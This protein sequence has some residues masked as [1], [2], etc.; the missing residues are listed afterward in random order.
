MSIDPD[1]TAPSRVVMHL[2]NFDALR[3]IFS[4]MV[5]FFH[6]GFL[7][8]SEKLNW[9]TLISATFAVQAFFFLSGFLVV[10][11]YVRSSNS[12]IY[13]L[14]RARRILPAYVAVVIGS[15]I[16]LVF[17]SRMEYIEYFLSLEF[18]KYVG[19]NIIFLNFNA[20]T[21]PGVFIENVEQAVNASLWTIKIEVAFYCIVPLVVLAIKRYNY[22]VVLATLFCA[23]LLWRLG[24]E[25]LG[26]SYGS[27]FFLK[28][29][30]QLPGQLSYFVAGAFSYYRAAEGLKSPTLFLTLCALLIYYFSEG[31]FFTFASPICVGIIVYWIAISAP[32]L[33]SPSAYGDFSYGIYLVHFPLVQAF[34]SLGWYSAQPSLALIS[35]LICILCFATF[36]WFFV[37]RPFIQGSFF[38]G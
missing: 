9:L 29:A 23:S 21:L 16:L 32:K 35:T 4:L 14:K 24:F 18:W 33:W 27:E 6:I 37:E 1:S 25:W 31:Y 2:G 22:Q 20:P 3:L 28:L 10:M 15:A 17:I 34:V 36:S 12:F 30:K 13:A 7:S 19:Y 26:H 5:V 8:G 38:K 11:S